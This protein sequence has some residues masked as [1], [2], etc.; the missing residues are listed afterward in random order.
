MEKTDAKIAEI[1]SKLSKMADIHGDE[2][3]QL[4]VRVVHADAMSDVTRGSVCFMGLLIAACFLKY[5]LRKAN[6]EPNEVP[7]FILTMVTGAG[8]FF[9]LMGAV[10]NLLNYWVWVGVFDPKLVLA[11]RILS[12]LI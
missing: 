12:S 9:L 8:G 6:A 4:A 10:V 11:K 3:L 2:A 5:F 1:L 7:Y